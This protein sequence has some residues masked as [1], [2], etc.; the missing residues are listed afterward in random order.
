MIYVDSR[1]K[2]NLHILEYFDAAGIFY[3]PPVA[4]KYGDYAL[5][6]NNPKLAIERKA[7]L[8]E[9]SSCIGKHHVRFRNELLRAR[10]CGARVIVL[11]EEETLP[12][13]WRSKRTKMTGAQMQKIMETMSGKY[14]VEWQFCKK[15]DAGKRII[16]ILEG[17]KNFE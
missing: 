12:C 9:L 6:R 2:S 7:H 13:D 4:L 16:E 15:A 10:D 11:I 5:E 14:P 17:G 3:S 1:E 8:L